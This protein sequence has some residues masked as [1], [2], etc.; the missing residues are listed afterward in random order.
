LGL[1]VKLKWPS[2][3][4]RW[5]Q[6]RYSPL[7]DCGLLIFSRAEDGRPTYSYSL[8]RFYN[9]SAR[10]LRAQAHLSNSRLLFERSDLEGALAE[11]ATA[12]HLQPDLAAARYRHAAM[13]CLSG[14]LNESMA[15]LAEAVR[16]D[17][18]LASRAKSDPDF[19]EIYDFPRFRALVGR[20]Q[21]FLLEDPRRRR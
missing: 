20:G 21:D 16:F 9:P 7:S 2:A 8:Q 19:A 11:A 3:D 6:V 5:E 17:A 18:K 15:E 4:W 12:A 13:L 14:Q 10:R 1:R